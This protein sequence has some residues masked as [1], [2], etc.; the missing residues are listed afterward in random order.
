MKIKQLVVID[1]FI[2]RDYA[3]AK[4]FFYNLLREPVRQGTGFSLNFS[5]RDSENNNLRSGFDFNTFIEMAAP[6]GKW[7]PHYHHISDGAKQYLNKHI[8]PD[9]FC[10]SYELP[11]WLKKILEENKVSYFD[12]RIAPLRFARDLYI[13]VNTNNTLLKNRL[14]K[15][16]VGSNEIKLEAALIESAMQIRTELNNPNCASGQPVIV[17]IGQTEFD[18]SLLNEQGEFVR[19]ADYA[20]QLK[21]YVG[22]HKLVYKAHP[23]AKEFA[24]KEKQQIEKILEQNIELAEYSVYQYLS[25]PTNTSFIGLSSSVLQEAEFFGKESHVL[26]AP[27]CPLNIQTGK[28]DHLLIRFEDFISPEFW[29][30][31]LTPEHEAPEVKK[32][33]Q[34]QASHLRQLHNVWW[35]Y[36]D[37]LLEGNEIIEKLSEQVIG[38][39]D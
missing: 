4:R 34:L 21:N 10:L 2:R 26:F 7:Q 8:L 23:W 28:K 33:P 24:V 37:Y 25:M 13:A 20:D 11:V 27:I 29:W 19:V 31:I 39:L 1:D 5:A 32:L 30:A 17:Y 9:S 15:F 18:A 6:D 35:G 38:R 3:H 12:F 22:T 16:I 14:A 36:A